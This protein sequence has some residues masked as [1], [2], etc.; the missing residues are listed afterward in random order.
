MTSREWSGYGTFKDLREL[1]MIT[2]N[3]RKSA[4]GSP[5]AEEV[6]RRIAQLDDDPS[7]RW[8]IPEGSRPG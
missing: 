6:H 4:A 2:T 7:S 5:Q 3:A 1:G 8:F